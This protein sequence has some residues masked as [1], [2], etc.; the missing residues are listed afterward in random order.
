L[1]G[2]AWASWAGGFAFSAATFPISGPAG[3][4]LTVSSVSETIGQLITEKSPTE[5]KA[6]NRS[7]LR[8]MGV[9]ANDSEHFL[10]NTSF[11]PTQQTTF[12][13]N[14]KALG[15]VA[16]R[17][18]FVHAAAE[19]S[20][21]EADALFCILTSDLMSKIH[22]TDKPLAR[23]V[24]LGDFPVSVAKDG[25]VVLA[26]QW[27][28]AAWTSA[29]ATFASQIQELARESGN[30]GVLIALSGDASPRLKQELQNR[31]FTVRDR[32]SSG[33]LK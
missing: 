23:I 20:S 6:I 31:G 15:D 16:N 4:A 18:A 1:D 19:M 26:L 33:P 21:N 14:L 30:K 12:V 22:A 25:T 28:Y 24:M 32:L 27:D 11:S 7:T 9:N 3:A 5:L 2:I 29:A 8:A 13:L 10:N 17:G